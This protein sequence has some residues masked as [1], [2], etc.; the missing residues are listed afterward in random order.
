MNIIYE[1]L[2]QTLIP[3][4]T[5]EKGLFDGAHRIYRITPNPGFVLH[6]NAADYTDPMGVYV[7]RFSS[8]ICTCGANY[9]FSNTAEKS[10]TDINGN[11][12]TVTAYGERGFFAFPENLVADP[13]NN[14]YGASKPETETI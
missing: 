12:V 1:P 9:D 14:I 3:N 13:E 4:T 5:M 11:T 7:Y 8:G 2:E 6:D 10:V